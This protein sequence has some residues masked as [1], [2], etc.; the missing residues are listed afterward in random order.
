MKHLNNE[1]H[2]GLPS[3]ELSA[4]RNSDQNKNKFVE[5]LI[6]MCKELQLAIVNGRIIR[7][8]LGQFTC[9]RPNGCST[10][11]YSMCSQSLLNNDI[12]FHIDDHNHLSDQ[13]PICL[14]IKK[15]SKK[16]SQMKRIK[17]KSSIKQKFVWNSNSGET[18]QKALTN[19]L[20][21]DKILVF[22]NSSVNSEI[23]LNNLCKVLTEIITDSANLSLKINHIR[24]EK[25][26]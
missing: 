25:V 8:L 6:N 1:F 11:D 4:R 20:I 3:I 10:V 5:C 9:F 22:N 17:N 26:A 15:N 7:D 21:K 16:F 13:A 24:K 12:S 18:F 19:P 2:I 23:E 14:H